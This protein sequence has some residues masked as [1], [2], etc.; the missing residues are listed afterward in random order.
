VT[1]PGEWA[2]LRAEMDGLVG[3]LNGLNEAGYTHI[4]GTFPLVKEPV[5][6]ATQEAFCAMTPD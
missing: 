3:H 4:L 6:Q 1:D 2:R 5:K